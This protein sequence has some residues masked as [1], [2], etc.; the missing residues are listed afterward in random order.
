MNKKKISLVIWIFII[1]SSI[2][3]FYS[4]KMNV[5]ILFILN[6]LAIINLL[7]L[8]GASII[9]LLGLF[10][11]YPLFSARSQFINGKSYGILEYSVNN[12]MRF[13]YSEILFSVLLAISIM[14]IFVC[15]TN[16]IDN[17]RNLQRNPQLYLTK[18]SEVVLCILAVIS[19][20]IAFP[21]LPFTYSS[22]TRFSALLPGNAWNHLTISLLCILFLNKSKNFISIA[23]IGL[24]TLWFLSHYERVDIFGLYLGM[25][26]LKYAENLYKASIKKRFLGVLAI[27]IVVFIMIFLGEKRATTNTITI[28]YLVS[29]LLVQNTATDIMYVFNAAINMIGFTGLFYGRT[30]VHYFTDAIP[31][32]KGTSISSLIKQFYS[33]P[34]GEYILV[35]P[36]INFRYVG[37]AVFLVLLLF[38]TSR[39]IRKQTMV[40]YIYYSFFI[41][42]I[43]RICWYGISYIETASLFFIPIIILIITNFSRNKFSL[44]TNS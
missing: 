7:L 41:C 12:G 21:S 20:F 32:F 13:N 42:T 8:A 38:L 31:L 18:E 35:E 3:F 28:D 14:I 36:Y 33:T 11:F 34:G 27:V 29:K 39:L 15:V 37:I 4:G 22:A 25:I 6:C 23:T 30:F 2:L 1:I 19:V 40:R 44:K 9:S 10:I 16:F 24:T 17:E 43:P 5:S 26:V